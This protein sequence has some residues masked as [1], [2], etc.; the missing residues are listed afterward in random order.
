MRVNSIRMNLLESMLSG[1]G[2]HYETAV[3]FANKQMRK[4]KEKKM[5]GALWG[6]DTA[7]DLQRETGPRRRGSP[8]Q[9]MSGGPSLYK[10]FSYIS[11]YMRTEL[12]KGTDLTFPYI[13]TL[14][15]HKKSCF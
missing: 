2:G 13:Y 5:N 6:T 7:V 11:L 3:V 12:Q 9:Q 15:L 1:R 8:I 14:G 10:T 4:I